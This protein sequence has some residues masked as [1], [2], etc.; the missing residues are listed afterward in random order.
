MNTCI[1]LLGKVITEVRDLKQRS[2]SV[3]NGNIGLDSAISA[4]VESHLKLDNREGV[5]AFEERLKSCKKFKDEFV[6]YIII[7]LF[8]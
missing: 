7:T 2:V 4:E 8:N 6:S 1:H 3:N 5:T